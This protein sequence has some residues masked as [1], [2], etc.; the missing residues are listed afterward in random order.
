M[1]ARGRGQAAKGG[2]GRAA[3]RMCKSEKRKKAMTFT[4][5]PFSRNVSITTVPAFVLSFPGRSCREISYTNARGPN[6]GKCLAWDRIS[7]QLSHSL[8]TRKEL[9]S[10]LLA[11]LGLG[12]RSIHVWEE[13]TPNEP[14][15]AHLQ[16]SELC[17]N[18][19]L[20]SCYWGS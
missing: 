3:R 19:L 13:N 20:V 16:R 1:W 6:L 5:V 4:F 14:R 2:S 9:Q 12:Y 15:M 7:H 18:I 11:S 10:A 8:V 17:W